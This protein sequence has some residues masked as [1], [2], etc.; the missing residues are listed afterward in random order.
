MEE[1]I[2]DEEFCVLLKE[3]GILL[4]SGRREEM[5]EL[6]DKIIQDTEENVRY[7]DRTKYGKKVREIQN[8][9][10]N[11]NVEQ[12]EDLYEYINRME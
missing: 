9:L 11:M 7:I 5:Q 3:L 8:K 2:T 10:N 12:I 6:M 4:K 1:Y